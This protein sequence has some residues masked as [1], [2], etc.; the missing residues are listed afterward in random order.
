[1]KADFVKQGK[2]E[3]NEFVIKAITDLLKV[4]DSRVVF[5]TQTFSRSK[6]S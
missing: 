6:I 2:E 1:M 5:P 4:L 3:M